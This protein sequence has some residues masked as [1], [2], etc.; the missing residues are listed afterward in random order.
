MGELQMQPIALVNVGMGS[1]GVD[2][3]QQWMKRMWWGKAGQFPSCECF[4]PTT[5]SQLCA[6][7]SSLSFEVD[8]SQPREG[9]E[10]D[11]WI[12]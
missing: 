1:C 3:K 7:K 6:I 2:A 9:D 5:S 11:D 12:F 4:E 8:V 10:T